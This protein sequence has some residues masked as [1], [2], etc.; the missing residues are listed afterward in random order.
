M[1]KQLCPEQCAA[2]LEDID[3]DALWHAGIRAIL[4]DLDNTLAAWKSRE[5]SEAKAAW[6]RR[7]TERFAVCIVSNT[8]RGQRLREMGERF[9]IQTVGKW[10]IGRKPG[11]G[12]IREAMRKLGCNAVETVMIGDQVMTDMWAGRRAGVHTILLQPISPVEFALTKITR[13][14]ERIALRMMKQRGMLPCPAALV[15]PTARR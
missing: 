11:P 6:V 15:P 9:H 14:F 3:L 10:L 1:L 7:A 13:F 4:L 12:G 8:I 2:K 5:V